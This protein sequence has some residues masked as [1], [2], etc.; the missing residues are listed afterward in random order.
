MENQKRWLNP[1]ELA[2]EFGI[3]QSTQAKLRMEGKIPYSKIGNKFIRYD[4][5][6]IDKWLEK[7]RVISA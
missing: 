1:K 6:E 3:A 4:R 2:Q 5:R 7:N